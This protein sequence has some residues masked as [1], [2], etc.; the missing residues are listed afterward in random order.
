MF[1]TSLRRAKFSTWTAEI[2]KISKQP[3]FYPKRALN[4]NR[5]TRL[6]EVYKNDLLKFNNVSLFQFKLTVY[7][8]ISV[9][10]Y[11]FIRNF[12]KKRR[13][14]MLC[15]WLPLG[16]LAAS[17][18]RSNYA[19]KYWMVRKIFLHSCGTKVDIIVYPGLTFARIPIEKIKR[20]T[21][22]WLKD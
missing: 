9:C 2:P 11:C 7:F 18:L 13:F 15:I 6:F 20:P 3:I 5:K 10:I 16:V 12:Q 1:K 19:F 17:T 21:P 14:R 22:E 8:A 4:F